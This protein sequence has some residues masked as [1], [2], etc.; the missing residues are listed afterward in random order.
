MPGTRFD[1]TATCL[2]LEEVV[3][4]GGSVL[5]WPIHAWNPPDL[6]QRHQR[7]FDSPGPSAGLNL[8]TQPSGSRLNVAHHNAVGE[9]QSRP[10]DFRHLF[11]IEFF[12]ARRPSSELHAHFRRCSACGGT[13]CCHPFPGSHRGAPGIAIGH[14]SGTW[15]NQRRESLVEVAARS[16]WGVQTMSGTPDA[17]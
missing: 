16:S 14:A 11:R 10:G 12:L 1:V 5:A 15:K 8:D 9:G 13:C 3:D 6:G 7:K 4:L 17:S 2:A